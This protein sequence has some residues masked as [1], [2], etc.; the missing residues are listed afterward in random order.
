VAIAEDYAFTY[1]LIWWHGW[2]WHE[3]VRQWASAATARA[4]F[5]NG[6][7]GCGKVACPLATA[8]K[9][10]YGKTRLEVA[11]KVAATTR[12]RDK[13][14]PITRDERQTI[15]QYLQQWIKGVEPQIRPS[16]HRRYGNYVRLHLVPGLG[17]I[18]L[19]KLTAQQLQAF[20]TAKL[21]EGLSSTTVHHMHCLLHRALK[22]AERMGLVQRNVTEQVRAPRRSTTEM[23]TLTQDQ[24]DSFLAAAQG[25]RFYALYVLA[26]TTGM[27]QGELLG[28]RWTD[29]DLDGPRPAL[30]VRMALQEDAQH[31]LVIAEPKT[32]HSR[33][34]LHL[35]AIAVEALRAHRVRQHEERLVLGAAWDAS[36]DLVFPNTRGGLMDPYKLVRFN[37][38]PIVQRAGLPSLR[39]HDLRHTAAT[40]LIS[41][42]IHHKVV[43]EMLSRADIA[44]TLRVYAHVTPTMQQAAVDIMDRMFGDKGA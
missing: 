20:Y 7:I 34:R 8:G 18:T 5:D 3:G 12:D 29:I 28:L 38:R 15:A 11:G 1:T 24:A 17:K 35:T 19:A 9:S 14:L 23:Q 26:L 41:H 33:R 42:G 44:T 2:Y 6:T 13:G 16:S 31:R 10:L 27:R 22:D 43:S 37:F 36:R 39:F 30:Q 32:P 21:A 4:R 40:L 25:D